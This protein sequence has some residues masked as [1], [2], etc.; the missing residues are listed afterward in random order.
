MKHQR[1]TFTPEKR[2]ML[3]S[4]GGECCNAC[5]KHIDIKGMH[6]DHILPLACGGSSDDDN[7]QTLCKP[8]HF[9]KTKSEQEHGYV[10]V[11]ETE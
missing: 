5:K 10:K 6:V 3:Y 7:L 4:D 11:S 8:R 2:E 1:I 9:D